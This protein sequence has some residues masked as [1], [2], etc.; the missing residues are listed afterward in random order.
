MAS[1]GA[2]EPLGSYGFSCGDADGQD[3]MTDYTADGEDFL[4]TTRSQPADDFDYS[5]EDR[6]EAC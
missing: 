2:D 3:R 6:P 5:G 1:F 4:A